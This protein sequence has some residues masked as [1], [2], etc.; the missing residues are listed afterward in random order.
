MEKNAS[1]TEQIGLGAESNI[2][3]QVKIAEEKP[4]ATRNSSRVP[5]DERSMMVRA[6]EK[7]ATDK[8]GATTT[9][10]GIIPLSSLST[11]DSNSQIESITRVC[12]ISLG[13]TEVVR[14][15]N[16]SIIQ[17]RDEASNAL[18]KLKEKML[19]KSAETIEDGEINGDMNNTIR[20]ILEIKEVGEGNSSIAAK[21]KQK[22][23]RN[24]D[25]ILEH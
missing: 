13:D 2:D 3:Q 9:K 24:E 16:I 23:N 1:Y 21:S 12:G 15:A 6:M 8:G 25:I 17:A 10:K 20:D 22:V 5:Q 19:A 4:Q 18:Q 11:Y 7:K 14:L